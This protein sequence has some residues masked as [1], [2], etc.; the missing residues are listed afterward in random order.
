[1]TLDL[2]LIERIARNFWVDLAVAAGNHML[3]TAAASG[4]DNA[5]EV[6]MTS[7]WRHSKDQITRLREPRWWFVPFMAK[8]WH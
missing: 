4:P 3:N 6:D 1:M 5:G 2:N 8:F 7:Q